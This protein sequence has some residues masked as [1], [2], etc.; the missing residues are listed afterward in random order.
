[1]KVISNGSWLAESSLIKLKDDGVL[2]HYRIAG[3][4]AA[5]ALSLLEQE[6]YNRTSLSLLELDKLAHDYIL[7]NGCEITFLDYHG[8]PNSIC[9][10]INK[11]LVHGVA[12]NYHFQ[13]GDMVS[14]DLGATF[15]GAIGDT[16]LTCIYGEP[17]SQE[18]IKI[19]RATK[20]ALMKGIAA[21]KMGKRLGS[22]GEAIWKSARGNG[23]NIIEQYGGHG[24]C[25]KDGVG[26][27]HALPFVANRAVSNEG[28][29][30]QPGMVLAVEPM[31]TDGSTKTWVDSDSWT[32]HCEAKLSSHEEHTI[33]IHEDHV[34]ILTARE[35]L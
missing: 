14:F 25:S 19:I 35:S 22:I 28:V 6:V 24:I 16:A 20:E 1:M 23:F 4:V 13:E 30:F 17:K 34:E 26:I 29:H 3:K 5:G 27:P 2:E 10:S 9:V 12:T 33:F 7:D 21:I 32:V 18:Q 31:L 11:Q 15:K 8:F